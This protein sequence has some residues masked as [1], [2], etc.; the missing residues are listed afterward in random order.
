M[1]QSRAQPITYIN[2]NMKALL[3]AIVASLAFTPVALAGNYE[4]D[5]TN[6]QSYGSGENYFQVCN[7]T[8]RSIVTFYTDETNFEHG[9]SIGECDTIWTDYDYIVVDYD[10]SWRNGDQLVEVRLDYP[11][12]VN[13]VGNSRDTAGESITHRMW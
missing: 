10:S 7:E 2:K 13:L 5:N 9:L 11:E 3:T 1:C 8:D 6:G 12:D 4:L